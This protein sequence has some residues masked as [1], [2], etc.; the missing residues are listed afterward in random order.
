[1]NM[2]KGYL[3]GYFEGFAA[4]RLS[5]VEANPNTSNQHEFNGV[6]QLKRLLGLEKQTLNARFL[7]LIDTEEQRIRAEG[8]LT[9]YDSRMNHPTRSEF[10]L[11]FPSNDVTSKMDVGDLLIITKSQDNHYNVI[12]APAGSTFE[13]QL[14]WLF[15]IS[16]DISGFESKIFDQHDDIELGFASRFILEELGLETQDGD[17]NLLDLILERF[18]SYFPSTRV[19]SEF[20]R[21]TLS[22]IDPIVDPDLA[23]LTWI[24][25]EEKLFRT[26]ER[27][28]VS[29]QLEK[30]F[31]DVDDF[32][33]YSLSVQNRRKSRVG[34]A[35]ENHIEFLFKE[36]KLL[37]TRGGE[38]ENKAKPDFLFPGVKYY[39]HD[40]FN[41]IFLTM[42]G[43][44]STCKDRWRQVLSEAQRIEKKH[45]FTLEP[46]I[47]EN[48]TIEMKAHQLTLVLP[49]GLHQTFNQSQQNEILGLDDFIGMVREN[50]RISGIFI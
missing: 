31:S 13:S 26:L 32:I 19:F 43:V 1:V 2:N 20:A 22:D 38:T 18:G 15:G 4:K 12:V 33:G 23:L 14:I 50:S 24:E 42:L 27:H 25:K 40:S 44:K 6:T 34:H 39:H 28:I 46:G 5:S 11:Y 10:R 47:S 49:K 45:L 35:L 16:S 7:F 8:F 36:N 37:F 3:S 41:P 21:S 48:Q 9:W 29:K 30:G 17:D